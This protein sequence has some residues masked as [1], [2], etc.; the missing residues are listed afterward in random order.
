MKAAD[1][2]LVDDVSEVVWM[3]LALVLVPARRALG[4]TRPELAR[5]MKMVLANIRNDVS[6]QVSKHRARR[7]EAVH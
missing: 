2:R 6:V 3:R 1:T 5:L 7:A 4:C